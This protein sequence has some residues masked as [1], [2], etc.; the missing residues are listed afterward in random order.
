MAADRGY[1]KSRLQLQDPHPTNR[2]TDSAKLADGAAR[3]DSPTK[4]D[5][6]RGRSNRDAPPRRVERRPRS[7]QQRPNPSRAQGKEDQTSESSHRAVRLSRIIQGNDLSVRRTLS[8]IADGRVSATIDEFN[9]VLVTLGR[10]RR[11]KVAASLLKLSERGY[12]GSQ[13][14]PNRTLKTITIMIDLYGRTR[15]LS[16]AFSLFQSMSSQGLMP[17]LVTYN[18]LIAACSRN[19]EPEKAFEV[20]GN[21]RDAGFAPDKFTYGALIDSCARRGLVD[22]AFEFAAM[23]EEDNVGKDATIFSALIDSC[24]KAGQINRALT[25]FEEMK[26]KAVWP[27]LITFAL[28]IDMC[29]NA[30]RPYLAFELFSEMKYWGLKPNVVVYTALID[31]CSKAGWPERAEAIMNHMRDEG[32]YPNEI[33][34]GAMVDAWAR[35]GELQRAFEIVVE[36]QEQDNTGPNT[37]LIGNLLDACRRQGKNGFVKQIWTLVTQFNLLPSRAHYPVLISLAVENQDF[38]TAIAAVAHCQA[39]GMCRRLSRKNDDMAL[40]ALTYSLLY[41]WHAAPNAHTE[42]ECEYV[43]KHVQEVLDA[44]SLPSSVLKHVSLEEARKKSGA[45]LDESQIAFRLRSV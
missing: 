24:G 26:R 37:V 11:L 44:A 7:S 19:N 45:L 32:V 39:R 20:F 25:V 21:M 14:V 38:R 13:I 9:N 16:R 35:Q 28:L 29:A 15:Q 23:M 12:F 18:A 22:R 43:R 34:H 33:T 27:N 42:A 36:A 8:D 41:L 31:A 10:Q 6:G 40:R 3:D 2:T 5:R 17:S 30:R 4:R 1:G